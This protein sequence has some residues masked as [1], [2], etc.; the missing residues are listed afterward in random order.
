MACEPYLKEPSPRALGCS[1]TVCFPCG[2]HHGSSHHLFVVLLIRLAAPLQ[3]G[4]SLFY[5]ISV[6][7]FHGGRERCLHIMVLPEYLVSQGTHSPL[8]F[9]LNSPSFRWHLGIHSLAARSAS[10][11]VIGWFSVSLFPSSLVYNCFQEKS[12]S[13]CTI[14]IRITSQTSYMCATVSP[15]SMP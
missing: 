5:D 13:N 15:F 6:L 2:T 7:L 9:Y 3:K 1:S 14:N 12:V 11:V 4:S 8:S 10:P